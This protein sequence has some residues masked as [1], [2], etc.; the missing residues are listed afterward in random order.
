MLMMWYQNIHKKTIL[1]Q[2][3]LL[4]KLQ[5]GLRQKLRQKF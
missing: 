1:H 4:Q 3:V 5:G 2:L